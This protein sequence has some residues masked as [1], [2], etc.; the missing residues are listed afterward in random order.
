[1]RKG[2]QNMDWTNLLSITC[3][4]KF[5]FNCAAWGFLLVRVATL[6]TCLC[7]VVSHDVRFEVNSCQSES[8]VKR[9]IASVLLWKCGNAPSFDENK[10]LLEQPMLVLHSKQLQ[11]YCIS[12]LSS[13]GALT[14][15]NYFLLLSQVKG[16]WLVILKQSEWL[17][18]SKMDVQDLKIKISSCLTRWFKFK[19]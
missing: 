15:S 5:F 11:V 8:G 9:K 14:C 4:A 6:D 10:Q 13:S 12:S 16:S 7:P 1:M 19:S 17:G 3:K 18:V 2:R